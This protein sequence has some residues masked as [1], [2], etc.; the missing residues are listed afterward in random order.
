MI[1]S[2]GLEHPTLNQ[3]AYVFCLQSLYQ[4]VSKMYSNLALPFAAGE[5]YFA[6]LVDTRKKRTVPEAP[7]SS[8]TVLPMHRQGLEPWTP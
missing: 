5:R 7:M 1:L 2:S 3:G 6:V 8:K 4:Y